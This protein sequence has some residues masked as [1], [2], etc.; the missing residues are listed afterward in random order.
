MS[1]NERVP[2]TWAAI[3]AEELRTLLLPAC[4]R[5]EIA[6]SIRRVTET[7]GDIDLVCEPITRPL[8]DMF[9]DPIGE[10][11][12]EL[13][14]LIQRIERAGTIEK[15]LNKNG[16]PSWGRD[17]KRAVYRG[18]A[19]DIQAVHD[20]TTWG[21][22]LAI[23]T[24]PADFNKAIVTPVHQGGLLPSGFEFRGGFRLYRFGGR[25]ETPTEESLFAALG[26]PWMDPVDRTA[27]SATPSGATR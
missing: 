12:D 18:I 3:V 15:R 14:D 2:W 25:V 27:P 8:T 19:V 4:T 7:V 5:I 23:R 22:W 1:G 11:Q 26:I 16:V 21:A 10:D 17:L 20:A 13:H 6:G 24:G 9:G